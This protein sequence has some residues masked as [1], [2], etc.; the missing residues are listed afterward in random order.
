MRLFPP[1]NI[2]PEK[3][4]FKVISV[5]PIDDEPVEELENDD[6][7]VNDFQDTDYISFNDLLEGGNS[8]EN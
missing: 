7:I 6:Y 5:E 3:E 4:R 2:E 1:R 8:N